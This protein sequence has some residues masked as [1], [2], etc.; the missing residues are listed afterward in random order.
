MTIAVTPARSDRDL[1]AFVAITNDVVPEWPTSREELRWAGERYPGGARFLARVDG[2]VAGAAT[3]G[4]IWALDAAYERWWLSIAVTETDRRRGIGGALLRACSEAAWAA[5]KTGFQ[6]DVLETRPAS[7]AFFEHRGFVVYERMQAVRLRVPGLEPPQ[8]A[9]P[10]GVALTTLAQRPDL[11]AGVHAVA[12]A[13]FPDIPHV[14]EPITAGTLEEFRVRDVDRPGIPHDGFF[15]AL[16]AASG[17]VVGY[18]SLLYAPG[19]DTI[20]YH[21]MTAVHPAWRGRGV[22][23][24]LKRA[25]IS[26]AIEHRLEW[27][28]T[29]NDEGNLP[30]RAVNARLGYTPTPALLGIRG[31]LAGTGAPPRAP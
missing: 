15:V 18:A 22:A 21:D 5:G 11:I 4:R 8:V 29:G 24:A 1:D 25:T 19:S 10:D 14:D 28:E 2:R 12:T 30:M 23:R 31:P 13:A 7:L 26:W 6:G 16:D 9:A 17:A 20:A 3:T 27:L